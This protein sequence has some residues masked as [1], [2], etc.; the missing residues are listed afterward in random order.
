K[1]YEQY[2]DMN[3]RVDLDHTEHYF[4]EKLKDLIYSA[5]S[6]RV[7]DLDTIGVL[8]SGGLDSSAVTCIASSLKGSSLKAFSGG[9]H[10]GQ[11]YDET[12]YAELVAHDV[13]AEHFKIFPTSEDFIN[14]IEEIIYYLDEPVAGPGSF[15]QYMIAN[16]ARDR[17]DTVLGGEG[18]DEI[19]GGYMRYLVAYL[20]QCIK[21][22]IN[23]S[24]DQEEYIVTLQTII[25][26]LS[27]LD[28]YQPML[29][30]FW[31]SG[32]FDP[33]EERYFKLIERFPDDNRLFTRDFA[34]SID[35]KRIYAEYKSIFENSKTASY[36]NKMSYFD[37]K[38]S[39]SALL[40]VDDRVNAAASLEMRGPLLDHRII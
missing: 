38:A 1:R 12:D 33:M 25:P 4:I 9:F 6:L 26:N 21:G 18:G 37:I 14:H 16:A 17:V 2:W 31:K 19:F 8:L 15:P 7:K 11:E 28:G 5:I 32:L 34:S 24:L 36:I 40:H 29:R 39:L 22:A 10:E 3:F 20:E 35:H 13:G 27:Q 30:D 23:E